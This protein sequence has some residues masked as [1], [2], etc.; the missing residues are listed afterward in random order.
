[1]PSST[2]LSVGVAYDLRTCGKITVAVSTME[3][4]FMDTTARTCHPG[5]GSK[6]LNRLPQLA[7]SSL[8]FDLVSELQQFCGEESWGSGR[9]AG[10]PRR[11]RSILISG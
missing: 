1:M 7:E 9:R 5:E 3:V 11:S 6:A 8:Q 4:L 10:V 2:N